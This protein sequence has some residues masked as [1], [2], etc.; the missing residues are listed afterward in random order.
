MNE[1]PLMGLGTFIGIEADFIPDIKTR[2]EVTK[3]S[4]LNALKIGYRQFDLAESY[5][6]LSAVGEALKIDFV[7]INQFH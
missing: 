5:G 1:M 2:M 4:I 3:Q 7:P 6:N